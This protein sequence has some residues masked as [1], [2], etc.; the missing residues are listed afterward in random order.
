MSER[1]DG[2]IR[3]WETKQKKMKPLS[4]CARL[5]GKQGTLHGSA[6]NGGYISYGVNSRFW[7]TRE[8]DV[9]GSGL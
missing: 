1:N 3:I 8:G 7:E 9:S 5:E 4:F 2:V 6:L